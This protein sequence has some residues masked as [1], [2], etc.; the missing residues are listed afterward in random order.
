MGQEH[1]IHDDSDAAEVVLWGENA[2]IPI[3]TGDPVEIYNAPAKPGRTG[4]I[5]LGVGRG[6]VIR[7]PKESLARLRSG[8]PS[9]RARVAHSS[10]TG[11]TG[12]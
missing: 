8:E 1:V 5:E 12:T 11:R 3:A 4:E 9:C 6:S 2:L 10:M 7:V